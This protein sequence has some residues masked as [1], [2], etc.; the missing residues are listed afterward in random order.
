MKTAMLVCYYDK[1]YRGWK[2][3]VFLSPAKA[4]KFFFIK[5]K[6]NACLEGREQFVDMVVVLL[7]NEIKEEDSEF[8]FNHTA[9]VE[10]DDYVDL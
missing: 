2:R 3:R 9:D 1:K 8:R 6:E 10:E 7:D 5:K 4:E